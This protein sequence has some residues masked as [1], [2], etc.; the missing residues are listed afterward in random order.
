[1]KRNTHILW[2]LS[3]FLCVLSASADNRDTLQLAQ[4]LNDHVIHKIMVGRNVHLT[5][6]GTTQNT[7]YAT[8][9]SDCVSKQI[10]NN[11]ASMK[12][13][14][15]F[16]DNR[17]D[18]C[19]VPKYRMDIRYSELQ[20]LFIGAYAEVIID[21]EFP[22]SN[23]AIHV[24][25]GAKLTVVGAIGERD[26]SFVL[27]DGASLNL[28]NVQNANVKIQ[29][30]ENTRLNLNG[31]F[32][33]LD[34]LCEATTVIEGIYTVRDKTME[35]RNQSHDADYDIE[36]DDNEEEEVD[37]YPLTK[38]L[39]EVLESEDESEISVLEKKCSSKKNNRPTVDIGA[40]FSV[41]S[42]SWISP[43]NTSEL[44]E[45]YN[46]AS[47]F[48]G[49]R[50]KL[51]VTHVAIHWKRFSITT[52]L[53][54]ESD[55][56][57][58]HNNVLLN[59]QSDIPYIDLAPDSVLAGKSRLVAR[60]LTVPLL[61]TVSPFRSNDLSFVFGVI[62]GFNI[63]TDHTGFKRDYDFMQN[64]MSYEVKE[65]TGAMY[66][67]FAPFKLDA[68]LSV[69]YSV[70]RIYLDCGLLPLFQSGREVKVIPFSI[71]ISLGV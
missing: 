59:T 10:S 13:H 64:G 58:F 37:V 15:L 2:F 42:V 5:V 11:V 12:N 14:V 54:Y 65:R 3:L 33:L 44:P 4:N 45:Q 62:G 67:N 52:G 23:Q 39:N 55:V 68:H 19:L 57:Y 35:I 32:T 8:K 51:S 38:V 17:S 9:K 6:F 61:F 7:F 53:G 18:V 56:F 1:M 69:G 25:E 16:I 20:E 29:A 26:I 21:G 28:M 27:E 24:G 63:R 36:E 60:Y 49:V 41:G 46:I 47:L 71:G 31:K 70:F 22:V 50:W 30:E 40:M 66:K 43:S 48:G 34:L